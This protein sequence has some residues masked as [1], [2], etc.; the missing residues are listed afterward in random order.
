MI[1]AIIPIEKIKPHPENYNGHP[2]A[3]LIQ[4]E[5]SYEE[6]GQ[7]NSIVV[8][9]RPGGEYLQV[10][11]HGFLE[12]MKRE[13]AVEVRADILPEDTDPMT[14]KRILLAD[15]LHPQNSATDEALLAE[16]L[17]EQVDAGYAL[18]ALGSDEESLRQMLES[19]GDEII[20]NAAPDVQFKEYDES[21]EEDL[22][23]E[24]C[25]QCGKVCL[26]SKEKVSA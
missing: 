11:R 19:L 21:V 5:A 6:F 24:L 17:Q 16:L 20:D 14:I 3:Q 10:A 4:L 2:D 12:A 23:T 8:W 25:Q 18:A 22:P 13:G 1:N 15:N 26:K 7:Y 9:Q